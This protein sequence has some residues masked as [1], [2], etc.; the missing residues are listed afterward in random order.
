MGNRVG[1][2]AYTIVRETCMQQPE[3]QTASTRFHAHS[4][5]VN[6]TTAH[7]ETAAP[8]WRVDSP[9][10]HVGTDALGSPR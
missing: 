9:T 1:C 3:R 5:D 8:G 2:G 4:T 7:V 6:I 10:N